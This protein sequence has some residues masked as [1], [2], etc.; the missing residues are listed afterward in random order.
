[1]I[2]LWKNAAKLTLDIQLAKFFA[3]CIFMRKNNVLN[4]Q[5]GQ[6]KIERCNHQSRDIVFY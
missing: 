1:M 6:F 4:N 5:L 2:H 3:N